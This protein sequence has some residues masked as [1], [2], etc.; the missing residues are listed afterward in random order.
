MSLFLVDM[1][2]R[3]SARAST[4]RPIRNMV[5]HETTEVFFDGSRNAG[6]EPRSARRARAFATSSTASTPSGYSSPPSA[7]AT[8][9]GSSSERPPTPTSAS[10]STGRSARTRACSFP[11]AECA[12]RDVEAADLMRW[13]ACDA[14]RHAASRAAPRRTWPSS[15]PPKASWEAAN[16]CLQTHGGFGFAEEYDI[17]RKF[18]ETRL[19]QVAPISTN[20]ILSYV[21]RARARAPPLVLRCFR[22]TGSLSSSLEQAVAAPFCDAPARRLGARVIK[23]E[24]PDD[25]DFARDY[26][27]AVNGLSSYFVWLN[28]SKESV[29]LD[30]KQ[31]AG[32]DVLD[33][34]LERADVFVQNLAP[35]RRG[36]ARTG[37]RRRSRERFP[38]LIVVDISGYGDGGPMSRSRKRTTCSSKP[39]AG[40]CRS[41]APPTR[42]RGPACRSPTSRPACTRT[43]GCSWRCSNARRPATARAST[44]RC[45]TRSASG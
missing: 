15:S 3:R 30:L 21:G 43:P 29:T 40:C 8:A 14:V 35:R 34:L 41:P 42:R 6:G 9:A 19:Y 4:L 22:S 10:S 44:C 20:L 33:R 45:S 26:D 12:R 23:I 28:R 18:R 1:Q 2:G 38:R 5:N 36:A 32:R 27:S 39:R 11:I 16:V 37:L 17:E 31:P 25:G 24:R 7:S 13:K